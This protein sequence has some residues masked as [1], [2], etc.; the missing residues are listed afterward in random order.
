MR[1]VSK[2]EN[3]YTAL[4]LDSC[5]NWSMKDKQPTVHRWIILRS[6]RLLQLNKIDMT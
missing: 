1:G 4:N 5:R 2:L 3:M 6:L